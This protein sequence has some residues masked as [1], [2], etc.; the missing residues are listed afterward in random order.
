[1]PPEKY[2][3]VIKLMSNNCPCHVGHKIGQEW[4]FDYFTPPKMCGLAFNAVYPF[5][6]ALLYG[7]KVP[8][9][10]DPDVATVSC[11]DPDVQNIFE[12]RRRV[13][14]PVNKKA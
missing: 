10:T 1:M 9:Q 7:A 2:E 8:W 6:L 5:A 12:L 3:V 14:Q 4:I 13:K 11:P